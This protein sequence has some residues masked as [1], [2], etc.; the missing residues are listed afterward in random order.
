MH[1]RFI[2]HNIFYMYMFRPLELIFIKTVVTRTHMVLYY[3][4]CFIKV[5]FLW[6][7][8]RVRC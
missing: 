8:Q 3:T 2:F 6:V 5:W 4:P 1:L 7:E